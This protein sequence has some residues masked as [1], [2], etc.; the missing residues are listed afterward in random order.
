MCVFVSLLASLGGYFSPFIPPGRVATGPG[1]GCAVFPESWLCVGLVDWL[2]GVLGKVPVP[3]SLALRGSRG[4]GSIG[5]CWPVCLVYPGKWV[6]ASGWDGVSTWSHGTA[7]FSHFPRA[8][9]WCLAT[10]LPKPQP[11][12]SDPFQKGG[13]GLLQGLPQAGPGSASPTSLTTSLLEAWLSRSC[14][15]P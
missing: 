9:S 7:S 4:Q 10:L 14:L 13:G 2:V 12:R 5:G 1:K 3:E 6:V 8:E 15:G 11:L